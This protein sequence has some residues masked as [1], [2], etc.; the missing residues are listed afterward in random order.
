[1]SFKVEFPIM[2]QMSKKWYFLRWNVSYVLQFAYFENL[3]GEA[4]AP[5]ARLWPMI[6]IDYEYVHFPIWIYRLRENGEER[7]NWEI[8]IIKI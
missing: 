8:E 2:V 3:G 6:N 7:W 5:C 1:M 4:G